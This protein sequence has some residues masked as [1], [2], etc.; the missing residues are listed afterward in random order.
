MSSEKLCISHTFHN[1]IQKYS[2]VFYVDFS[3]E[4]IVKYV[5]MNQW[6]G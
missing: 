3:D 5:S 6:R 2:C 1:G 4:K